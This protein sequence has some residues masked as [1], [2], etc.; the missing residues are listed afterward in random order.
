MMSCHFER[1]RW[2]MAEPKSIR[3]HRGATALKIC[4]AVLSL[5]GAYSFFMAL[6]ESDLLADAPPLVGVLVL[7]SGIF[8]GPLGIFLYWRGRQYA[9]RASAQDVITASKAHVLYL[10]AFETD[11]SF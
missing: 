11:R 6:K 4:G 3:K 5:V 7:L 8:F 9:A 2:A 10:R 1:S